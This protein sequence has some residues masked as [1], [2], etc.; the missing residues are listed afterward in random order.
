MGVTALDSELAGLLT[1]REGG[2]PSHTLERTC[3]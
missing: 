3:G 1:A 2:R